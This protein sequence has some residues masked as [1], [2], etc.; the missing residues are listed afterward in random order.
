MGWTSVHREPGMTDR[1]FFERVLPGTLTREGEILDST[2]IRGVFYAAVRQRPTAQYRPGETWCAVIFMQRTG[3]RHNCRYKE[4]ADTSHPGE[5]DCPPR[6]LDLLSPTDSESA[7]EWRQRCRE[8]AARMAAAAAVKAGVV[9]RF[10]DVLRFR[11][12][13]V[14]REFM[15]VR[16]A[17]FQGP[18]GGLYHIRNWRNRDYEIVTRPGVGQ[19][20]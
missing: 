13:H 1:A 11:D 17:V 20:R 9:I 2:T 10:A 14:G 16:G 5:F 18:K 8:Q 3:G 12:G 4:L 15:Y 7:N 6:I 19:P